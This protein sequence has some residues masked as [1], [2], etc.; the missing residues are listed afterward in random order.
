[1]TCSRRGYGGLA[2]SHASSSH[3]ESICGEEGG[4]YHAEAKT[5]G[6]PFGSARGFAMTRET[7]QGMGTAGGGGQSGQMVDMTTR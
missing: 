7:L 1:M 3:G 6:G 4:E 5:A 2:D